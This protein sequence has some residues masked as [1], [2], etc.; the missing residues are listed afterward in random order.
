[1]ERTPIFAEV[2]NSVVISFIQS[3]L[4]SCNKL[5]YL[6]LQQGCSAVTTKIEYFEC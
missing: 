6:H 2:L 4:K 3:D 5:A 1:M